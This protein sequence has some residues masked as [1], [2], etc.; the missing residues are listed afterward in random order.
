MAAV[1]LRNDAECLRFGCGQYGSFT[2]F[3]VYLR[4]SAVVESL[5][6]HTFEMGITAFKYASAVDEICYSV[7]VGN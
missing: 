3:A 1:V 5:E 6:R 2:V 7:N 4:F